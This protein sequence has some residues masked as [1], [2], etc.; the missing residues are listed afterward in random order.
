MLKDIRPNASELRLLLASARIS[1]TPEHQD[2]IR[3]ILADGLDWTLFAKQ[4]IEHGLAPLAGH[5]LIGAAPEM[6]PEDILDALNM[7][8]DH[9]RRENRALF[10]EL[11]RVTEALAN[12]G[13]DAI[14][15][16][17]P[18]LAMQAYGDLG[19]R[20]SGGLDLL[21]RDSDLAA[22]N[23]ILL[24]LGYED[25][26]TSTK[27][28]SEAAAPV[29]GQG[30]THRNGAGISITSH[31]RLKFGEM[32]LDVTSTGL[33][34]RVQRTRVNGRSMPALA[35][36]DMLV[37]LAILG[38]AGSWRKIIWVSDI[39]AFI[40]SHRE[41]DW[42]TVLSRARAQGCL[43]AVL[44]AT[45]LVRKYFDAPIPEFIAS[46]ELA[47]AA[48]EPMERR[49]AA[50]WQ[51]GAQIGTPHDKA[52]SVAV[53]PARVKGAQHIAI[54]PSLEGAYRRVLG[55]IERLP[56]VLASSD[57]ALA[58]LPV[59]SE[60]KLA[61]RQNQQ[62][63]VAA[64]RILAAD[65][66]NLAG[67]RNL[68]HALFG[69][70]R[71]KQAISC[72]EKALALE[73]ENPIIWNK[74][75]DALQ[76][77]GSEADPIF[78]IEPQSADAWT[79]RA[80]ALWFSKRFAEAMEAIDRAL[81]LD[82]QHVGA[83]RMGI[84]LRLHSCDW[85]RREDD[86]RRITAGL[87]AGESIIRAIDH[88]AVCDREEELRLSAQLVAKEIQRSAKPLWRGDRYS[89][90]KIRVAYISTDFRVHAV[91]SLVVG[92][93]E[94]HD[95]TRF[96]TT[97]ISLKAGDGSEMRRRIETAFDRFIDAHAMKDIVVAKML[98]DLE[99]DI[100]V[101]LNG[102]TGAMR[103]GIVARRPAPVQVS[104]LGY[105]GTM[106][107]QFIDYI[108]ADRVVIPE[109]HQ[110]HYSEKV[111]Y[112]PDTYLPSD[113]K[114]RIG[115]RALSRIEAELPERGFVFACLNNT[116][117]IGPE[118]FEVWMRILR[119]VDGSVLWLQSTTN[120]TAMSNLRRE[121]K[122][123]G[124]A[125]DRLVFA[126]SVPAAEDHLA[127]L[128]VA[129]LFLDTVPYNAHTT[130]SD[131]LWAGL[132]VLTCPGKSFPARVAA[133][134]LCAIGLPELV[135]RSLAE[136]EELAVDLAR[137][138]ERLAAVKAKLMR[139]LATEPLFDTERYTRNLESAYTMM[140]E[141]QQANLRPASFSVAQ[142]PNDRGRL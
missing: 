24:G 99:I 73:P 142:S 49:I 90:D 87:K 69:L 128:R 75:R 112:L 141:R 44:L 84:H 28:P 78:A 119:A 54:L 13:I 79:V 85:R 17:G 105:P 39:A 104:Y 26:E 93:L 1:A 121:A 115:E 56:Y 42:T 109:E 100:A 95:K 80:G 32:A 125:P 45:S 46:L 110:I 122:A 36:E 68:G 137:N 14:P 20:A 71:Y 64:K 40:V 60:T 62:A 94:H 65:P 132:P 41:L 61:I 27:A 114:R 92:C 76:A 97:A 2:E 48:I 96:E 136:Y 102:Y 55:Q 9:T 3:Q 138:P 116:Y 135:A 12:L 131:A 25:S 67:W 70:K 38:S 30:I 107:V 98:R 126:P 23:G 82:P 111:I 33:W 52:L 89:H 58:V 120:T 57:L 74:R 10:E 51:A 140:W 127:R 133:S 106:D 4:A 59:S 139:N 130:A 22:S 103:G 134:L 124:V 6:M 34:R 19:L 29:L 16:K 123:Q 35:S 108:I 11:F 72:F 88:R 101:D 129:D 53:P 7:I 15:F 18:M 37:L 8:V 86:K 63:L 91:A 43:H 47:D 31:T 118:V 77:M 5:T 66:S 113:R 50:R 117:K 83:T 81:D 21:I